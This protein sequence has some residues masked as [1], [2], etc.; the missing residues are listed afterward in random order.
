MLRLFPLTLGGEKEGG[1]CGISEMLL[2]TRVNSRGQRESP[3]EVLARI[4]FEIN[5]IMERTLGGV[6]FSAR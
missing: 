6:T 1:G 4:Q 3:V 2:V 5:K